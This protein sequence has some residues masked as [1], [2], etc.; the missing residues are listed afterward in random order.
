MN[1]AWAAFKDAAIGNMRRHTCPNSGGELSVA[2]SAR[3]FFLSFFL[4]RKRAWKHADCWLCQFLLVQRMLFEVDGIVSRVPWMMQKT[5]TVFRC[6]RDTLRC[7]CVCPQCLFGLRLRQRFRRT[8]RMTP[9]RVR[10]CKRVS[11]S[12]LDNETVSLSQAFALLREVLFSQ[13]SGVGRRCVGVV[14]LL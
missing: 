14:A 7:V 4:T 12:F 1:C 11:Q 6:W 3:L 8:V 9:R 13:S 10:W 5:V 2:L